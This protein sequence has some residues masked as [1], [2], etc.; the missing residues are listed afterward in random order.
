MIKSGI[1]KMRFYFFLWA[2]DKLKRIAYNKK[3]K[4]FVLIFLRHHIMNTT[5]GGYNQGRIISLIVFTE[6]P[7][8]VM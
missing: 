1:A 8:V 6:K 5:T 3:A 2:L 7:L 4:P